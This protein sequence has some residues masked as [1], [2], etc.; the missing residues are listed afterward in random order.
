MNQMKQVNRMNQVNQM[1]QVNHVNLVNQKKHIKQAKQVK[2]PI[3]DEEG[4][5]G[6][7]GL[8]RVTGRASLTVRILRYE[9]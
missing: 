5:G 1:N 8:T 3:M 4:R 7:G 9:I 2:R 6:L